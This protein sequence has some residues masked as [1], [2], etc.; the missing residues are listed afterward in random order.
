MSKVVALVIL[1]MAASACD[2]VTS[3]YST[4]D[5]ARKDRLFERGWLPNIL[6]PSSTDIVAANNLDTNTSKGGF[7]FAAADGAKFKQRTQSGAPEAAPVRDWSRERESRRKSGFSELTYQAAGS[8]W[9]FFC[10]FE[11]GVCEYTMWGSRG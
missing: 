7:R 3:R 11:Q 2:V 9:V 4:L 6:P 8:T 10:K 1:A 5:E